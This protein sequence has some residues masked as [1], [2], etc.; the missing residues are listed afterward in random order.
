MSSFASRPAPRPAPRPTVAGPLSS[1]SA[2]T[3]SA[4]VAGASVL[5][6]QPGVVRILAVVADSPGLMIPAVGLVAVVVG[7]VA[8][9]VHVSRSNIRVNEFLGEHR[10]FMGDD[11][12]LKVQY[13]GTDRVVNLRQA[14]ARSRR[15]PRQVLA[16]PAPV[17]EVDPFAQHLTSTE[18]AALEAARVPSPTDQPALG[19]P[20]APVVEA[21][22][23]WWV[24][25]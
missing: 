21:A 22:P 19:V 8:A 25:S 11:G 7:A 1:R 9:S 17:V 16:P 24:A 6:A 20:A 15:R 2:L 3:A 18:L 4:V 5:V 23:R 10:V 12:H 14:P 13:A